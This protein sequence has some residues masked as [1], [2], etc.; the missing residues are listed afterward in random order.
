[1]AHLSKFLRQQRLRNSHHSEKFAQ[2]VHNKPFMD[3]ALGRG[4][5][6][7]THSASQLPPARDAV[8]ALW[9]FGLV[10]SGDQSSNKDIR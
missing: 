9:I 3:L 7:E 1:M 5:S 6:R 4:L 10:S 2:A 8:Y